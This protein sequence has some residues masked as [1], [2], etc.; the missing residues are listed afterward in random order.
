MNSIYFKL[1]YRYIIKNKLSSVINI[2]G[3]SVGIAACLFILLFIKQEMSYDTFYPNSDEMYRVVGN[4]KNS[5][6]S[7]KSGFV[8]LPIAKDLKKEIP[9]IENF[10]RVSN[11]KNV[12]ILK[13]SQFWKFNEIRFA[14]RNFFT[15]F[16]FKLIS[17][18]PEKI[19][20]SPNEIVLS[21]KK[22]NQ[23]FGNKNPIGKT[24]FYNGEPLTIS[25]IFA[26][27]PKNTHL[28]FD[29]ILP[30]KY[31]EKS[32]LFWKGYG[33][34]FTV[35][36]YLKLQD[37]VT[38]QQIENYLPEFFNRKINKKW[39]GTGFKFTADLQN[40]KDIHLSG[41]TIDNDISSNRNKNSL[42]IIISIC[43]LILVL[44]IINYILLYTA[45][46][47][48]KQ[49]DIEILKIF[50]A[51]YSSILIQTF[52]EIFMISLIASLLGIVLLSLGLPFLNT[53]IQSYTSITDEILTIILVL[54]PLLFMLS[55]IVTFFSSKKK[56]FQQLSKF[57]SNN[58]KRSKGN[59]LVSFQFTVVIILMISVLVI[60]GQNYFLM[61]Q[62]LGFTKDHI[63]TLEADKK[64]DNNELNSF[65][66][67]LL[68]LPE[69][70]ATCLTSQTIGK[71]I[72]RNGY[73][74]GNEIENTML[75][76]LYV[77]E[78][79]LNCFGINLITG[80]N[81]K[82]NAEFDKNSIIINKKLVQRANWDYPI[83]KEIFRD[84]KLKVI[85]VVDDFNFE[86]LEKEVQPILIM[87]N[88]EWDGWTYQIVNIKFKTSN[89]LDLRKR[90]ENL[91]L[92]RFPEVPFEISFLDQILE[93]NYK[94]FI[95]QQKIVSFFSLIAILIALI[96]LF[97]L[98]HY[99]TQ[100]RSKEIAIRKVNGA[101]IKDIL[102]LLNKES[103]KSILIANLIAFPVAYYIMQKWLGNFA[104]KIDLSWWFFVVSA[105]FILIITSLTISWQSLKVAMNNPIESL[106]EE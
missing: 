76:V 97:G 42:Y 52:I 102:I 101:S 3:F 98:T 43:L 39:E 66:R 88:P 36:S 92:N 6:N 104:Y 72:T 28:T 13:D 18:N 59:L 22:A 8:W 69:I 71:G 14:D 54:V 86:S 17:G 91:W 82:S 44:A 56:S 33:G 34:G 79:F 60:S 10:C 37:N 77:D 105:I 46:K 30:I 87:N 78:D 58:H 15:F 48:A 95:S 19:L 96:G 26:N 16:N 47:I 67:A 75:N 65:K 103:L 24:L 70:Q 2:I 5:N 27:I 106:K 63:L 12:K 21:Q 74:I 32:D 61:Q 4:D 94:T 25:G 51:N 49:K 84:G 93:S 57:T 53:H 100:S 73:T 68:Q 35:L 20:D 31:I 1:A 99:I 9:G 50:G 38:P 81:F 83:D 90:I 64:F 40:I 55:T 89:I 29:A 62:N 23:L 85:G 41:G 7:S 45:Q 11:T 80:R